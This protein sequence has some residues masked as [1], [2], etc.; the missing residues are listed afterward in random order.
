M[1][2]R[3]FKV[4]DADPCLFYKDYPDGHRVLRV[5]HVD[6]TLMSGRSKMLRWPVQAMCSEFET[7]DEGWVQPGKVNTFLGIEM[8]IIDGSDL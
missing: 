2:R 6:D 3:G 4:A 8:T 5:L 1:L 7:K